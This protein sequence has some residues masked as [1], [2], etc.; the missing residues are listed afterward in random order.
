MEKEQIK[1]WQ[2]QRYGERILEIGRYFSSYL[3][4][5]KNL[6]FIEKTKLDVF[7]LMFRYTAFLWLFRSGQ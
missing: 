1:E 7:N 4:S 3:L 6:Y 5:D 2:A